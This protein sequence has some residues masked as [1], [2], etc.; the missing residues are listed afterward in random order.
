M[1]T[2]KKN[3]MEKFTECPKQVKPGDR[4]HPNPDNPVKKKVK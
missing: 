4:K 1:K 2:D 3:I